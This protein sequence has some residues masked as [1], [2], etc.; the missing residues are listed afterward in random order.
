MLLAAIAS[1]GSPA[2]SSARSAPTWA[3]PRAPPPESASASRGRD[4]A[5]GGVSCASAAVH[6]AAL[7]QIERTTAGPCASPLPRGQSVP[8]LRREAGG[9]AALLGFRHEEGAGGALR[10][11]PAGDRH[12]RGARRRTSDR[13]RSPRRERRAA[14]AHPRGLPP[15]DRAG[16]RLRRA[17]P[18][19]HEGRR[20]SSAGT[21]T[22]SRARP[23]SRAIPSSRAA[24]PARRSTACPRPAGS[25]RT[26]RS[27]SSRRCAPASGCRSCVAPAST[28]VSSCPRFEELLALVAAANQ[29]PERRARPLGV[30]PE[31]KHPSY[32]EAL[33]LPLEARLRRRAA[34]PRP[35]SRRRARLHPVVRGPEPAAARMRSP[36]CRS[37]S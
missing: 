19:R 35:R 15:R 30:Y 16:R 34:P 26:S 22:R 10:D 13:H 33:G 12:A 31:T 28:A 20:R 24:V 9:A 29:R 36:A 37:S 27:P 11:R 2:S 14:R 25:P 18:R 1:T 3:M 21:R 7:H 5:S 23:T 4:G 17:G 32:F 6:V 8:G